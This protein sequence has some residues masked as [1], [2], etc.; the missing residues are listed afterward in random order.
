M[1]LSKRDLEEIYAVATLIQYIRGTAQM[2]IEVTF[3]S[4]FAF[5]QKTS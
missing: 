1:I 4:L 2:F 5:A 3:P